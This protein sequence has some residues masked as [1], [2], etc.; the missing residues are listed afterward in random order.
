M[1]WRTCAAV[2]LLSSDQYWCDFPFSHRSEEPR[3]QP[4]KLKSR[5]ISLIHN[6]YFSETITSKFYSELWVNAIS[7]QLRK[8]LCS[9]EILRDLSSRWISAE[10]IGIISLTFSQAFQNI[11]SKFAYY[12]NRFSYANSKLKIYTRTQNKVSVWNSHHECDFLHCIFS[13]DYFAELTK[14]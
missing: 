4:S 13:Q 6:I 7:T 10:F 14:R 8:D 12:R 2:K 1:S 11:L 3:I 9:S 5:E